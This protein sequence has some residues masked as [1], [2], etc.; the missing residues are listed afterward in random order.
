MVKSGLLAGK[1]VETSGGLLVVLDA[2]SAAAFC[3]EMAEADGWPSTIVG[4][5]VAGNRQVTIRPHCNIVSIRS[6]NGDNN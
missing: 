1:A 3:A 5:V 4:T 2:A 6:P